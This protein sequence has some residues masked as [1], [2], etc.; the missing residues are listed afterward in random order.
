M[1]KHK[2]RLQAA[3][4]TNTE[5]PLQL[6]DSLTEQPCTATTSDDLVVNKEIAA[7]NVVDSM[8]AV[9]GVDG[10]YSNDISNNINL[11]QAN[12]LEEEAGE[13]QSGHLSYKVGSSP[14]KD[15]EEVIMSPENVLE[16]EDHQPDHY[17]SS[18]DPASPIAPA[19]AAAAASSS[20]LPLTYPHPSYASTTFDS[21]HT[22]SIAYALDNNTTDIR[23]EYSAVLDGFIDETECESE[24][25]L[26][27]EDCI[28][29]LSTKEEVRSVIEYICDRCVTAYD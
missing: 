8:S 4:L 26:A 9:V 11:D 24:I 25:Y 1:S 20:S 18:A 10:V 13:G 21:I 14:S 6:S 7:A 17:T 27:R 23:D 2:K 12:S 16:E 15:S 19:A 29:Y 5:S 3:L 28:P 22:T